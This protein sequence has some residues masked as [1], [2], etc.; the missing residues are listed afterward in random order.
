VTMV[1]VALGNSTVSTCRFGD[2]N[3]DGKITVD[4]ILQAVTN[5]LYGCGVTPPTPTPTPALPHGHTCCECGNATCTDFAW[6]EVERVCPLGCQT[7]LDA[8]CEAP[9]HPGPVGGPAVCVPLT[10]CTTDADCDDG[11]G[12]SMDQCTIDGCTHVCVCD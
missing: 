1:N 8:E 9:C 2:A 5:A 6:V 12:C 7:F 3:G 11:N 4:E 10:P